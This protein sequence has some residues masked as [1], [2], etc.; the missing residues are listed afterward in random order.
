MAV[1]PSSL[2]RRTTRVLDIVGEHV[3]VLASSE[4]TEGHETAATLVDLPT[5]VI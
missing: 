3:T 1:E 4:A 5:G 2:G